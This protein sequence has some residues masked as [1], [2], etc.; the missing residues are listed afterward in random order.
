MKRVLTSLVVL[1][2]VFV[3]FALVVASCGNETVGLSIPFFP[4][5]RVSRSS[6]LCFLLHRSPACHGNRIRRRH[7][8]PE[9]VSRDDA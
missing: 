4:T 7:G 2:V 8:P 6:S 1:L 3:A 5:I 9:E